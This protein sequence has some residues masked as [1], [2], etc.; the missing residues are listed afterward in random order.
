MGGTVAASESVALSGSSWSFYP[1]QSAGRR[2][3]PA[4]A[5][6]EDKAGPPLGE[7][8]PV[9]FTVVTKAP[10][11]TINSVAAFTKNTTPTLTGGAGVRPADDPSVDVTIYEGSVVGGT[12]AASEVV[13]VSGSTWSFTRPAEGT[14][15]AQATQEDKLRQPRRKHACDVHGAHES[16]RGDDQLG[17][18][19]YEKH[20][21][22]AVRGCRSVPGDDPSVTVTIYKGPA[23]GGT[24]AQSSSVAR[25]GSTWSLTAAK[26]AEGTYTAQATQ[27]DKLGNLGEST[28]VTFAVVTK[29]PAVTINSVAAFTK[30]TTPTLTGGA[31]VRSGRS[32]RGCDDL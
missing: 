16:P 11:V 12:V 4:Q 25:S 19:L 26:L 5:T 22:D 15:T 6:Q 30:N 2:D 20:E 27:E 31:G 28:P 23:V 24:I 21:A 17:G 7:S 18:G 32:E 9:T 10:A 8:T 3:L 14:Y 13:S 29:A 1:G